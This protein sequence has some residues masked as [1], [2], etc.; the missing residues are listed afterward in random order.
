MS[1]QHTPA[2]TPYASSPCASIA[3]VAFKIDDN[4]TGTLAVQTRQVHHGSHT[5][6]FPFRRVWS[7]IGNFRFSFNARI[8]S[9]VHER[10]CRAREHDGPL[11]MRRLGTKP[12]IGSFRKMPVFFR[13]TRLFSEA[14][15]K[16]RA[17]LW[18]HACDTCHTVT[19]VAPL[20]HTHTMSVYR[21]AE[22]D[23]TGTSSA[24]SS[25]TPATTTS[26]GAPTSPPKPDQRIAPQ[27]SPLVASPARRAMSQAEIEAVVKHSF[28]ERLCVLLRKCG[29]SV[30][31]CGRGSPVIV[32]CL[33]YV[34][35]TIGLDFVPYDTLVG[36]DPS[37][38]V[39]SGWLRNIKP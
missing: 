37:H 6:V 15:Y 14:T 17:A 36:L 13:P 11:Y 26:T 31:V 28:S 4:L 24:G 29:A 8:F 22:S 23:P 32:A 33:N 3:F 27:D 19:T 20:L 21:R 12:E 1:T 16:R 35:V 38:F 10:D 5:L 25:V 9:S 34:V 39:P 30:E 2:V 18:S 7:K